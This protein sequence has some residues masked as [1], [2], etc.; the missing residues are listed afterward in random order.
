MHNHALN[1]LFN[2]CRISRERQEQAAV[3]GIIPSLKYFISIYNISLRQVA[4]QTICDIAHASKKARSILWNDGGIYIFLDLLRDPYWQVN[5]LEAIAVWYVFISLYLYLFSCLFICLFVNFFFLIFVLFCFVF[6]CSDYYTY[7]TG[8]LMTVFM[9]RA[10]SLNP[11]V[12]LK[13]FVL[14]HWLNHL[15]LITCLS[16]YKSLPSQSLPPLRACYSIEH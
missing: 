16:L 4:L 15:P 3:C 7:T 12:L 6:C 9:L 2:F 10:L 14:F 13:L 5:A 8:L 11:R 1:S